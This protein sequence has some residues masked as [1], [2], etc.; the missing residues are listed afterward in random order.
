VRDLLFLAHRIPYPPDKGD[1]IRSCHVLTYLSRRFRVHLGCFF[2]DS[3]DERH[4]A[5]LR[6]ICA[7]VYCI[8]LSRAKKIRRGLGGLITGKSMSETVYRDRRMQAWVRKII[9]AHD[10]RD[11]FVFC[12]LMAPYVDVI[13]HGRR[14]VVDVVDVDSEK[15]GAYAHRA[16]WPLNKVYCFEQ[17]HVRSL[18]RRAAAGC[19]R[20]LFVSKAEAATFLQFAPELSNQV[21]ILENG[22]DVDHFDPDRNYPNPFEAGN[23]AIVFTG[24]MDYWPNIDAVAWFASEALPA[25]RRIHERAQF[26]IV[27]TNPA[28]SVRKLSRQPGVQVTGAV[29]DVR[30]YLANAA[31]CIAPM[32][33]ARG[34]Q[35][36]VLEAM[37]MAKPVVLT[38]AAL[39]GLSAIPKRDV[40]VASD[41]SG[42]ADCVIK[43]LSGC[44][45]QLS[46]AA[47]ARIETDYSW[48]KNLKVLDSLYQRGPLDAVPSTSGPDRQPASVNTR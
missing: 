12:S 28:A 41:A 23:P 13:K 47:R 9:G 16:R 36:K 42:F 46:R 48:D 35:N 18:E 8:P 5:S 17:R 44:A 20:A 39:E 10:I 1:K 21:G 30:P 26:W 3:T 11:I 38:P 45:D 43:I 6:E 27:G 14:I 4:V 31:C 29:K 40:L 33:I 2:D 32:R 37:A 22:V 19:D 34:V 7:S 25:V 24:V 15:W